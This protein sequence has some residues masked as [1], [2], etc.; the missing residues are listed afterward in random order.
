MSRLLHLTKLDS[1]KIYTSNHCISSDFEH[2]INSQ[3]GFTFAK[4]VHLK[5]LKVLQRAH[6]K[7]QKRKSVDRCKFVEEHW[8]EI[9][10][11]RSMCPLDQHVVLSEPE[12]ELEPESECAPTPKKFRKNI[13]SLGRQQQNKRIDELYNSMI[14]LAECEDIS[15]VTLAAMLLHRASY[16][17]EKRVAEIADKVI[18]NEPLVAKNLI[19]VEAG[20][21]LL[22]VLEVGRTPYTIMR[23]VFKNELGSHVL[24][25]YELV[26][27][28]N[29][30]ITPSSQPLPDPYSG[31]CYPLFQAIQQTCER[32]L[33]VVDVALDDLKTAEI[34]FKA[35]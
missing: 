27:K 34:V 28:L 12:D 16:M 30:E 15:A 33:S 20:S 32:Q 2:A 8:M 35:G 17:K 4:S 10:Y 18:H 5:N 29:T 26:A 31:M 9:L 24:P 19:S 25:R 13:L 7:E 14:L 6:E 11:S 1:Y 23:T 3:F 21:L 22:S